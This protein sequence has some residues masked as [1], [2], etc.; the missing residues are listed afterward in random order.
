MSLKLKVVDCWLSKWYRFGP[1]KK[2]T[3]PP[4]NWQP[5]R[6]LLLRYE[7][8][9]NVND[10]TVPA[11]GGGERRLCCFYRQLCVEPSR[12]RPLISLRSTSVEDLDID[13]F[14][15]RCLANAL[16]DMY[17]SFSIERFNHSS[18]RFGFGNGGRAE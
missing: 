9:Y 14:D 4:C 6:V 7:D 16:H 13:T 18:P 2:L 3:I 15:L 5:P 1:A 12:L 10:C 17:V 11:E 8:D